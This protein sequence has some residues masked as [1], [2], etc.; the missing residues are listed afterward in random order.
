MNY[1]NDEQF[2]L[3]KMC[4]NDVLL[5]CYNDPIKSNIPAVNK[6]NN[7]FMQLIL[8]ELMFRGLENEIK[9]ASN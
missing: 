1:D 2:R 5:K 9:N 4:S 6:Q 7:R 8:E 3:I